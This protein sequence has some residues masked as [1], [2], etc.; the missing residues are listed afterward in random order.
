MGI[1]TKHYFMRE[2]A[3]HGARGKVNRPGALR[4]MGF[5]S[6]GTVMRR[7]YDAKK[8]YALPPSVLDCSN[9]GWMRAEIHSD[10]T[11]AT[12][13]LPLASAARCRVYG[14]NR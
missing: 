12:D 8:G 11:T 10:A 6:E 13:K 2:N 14:L 7:D 1:A 5:V 9:N 3:R 4:S